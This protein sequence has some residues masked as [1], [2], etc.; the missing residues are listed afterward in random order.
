MSL[1]TLPY[2]A[3]DFPSDTLP[4]AHVTHQRPQRAHVHFSIY[5]FV[6]FFLLFRILRL[7][8]LLYI[9]FRV[10]LS[11]S[12]PCPR[13]CLLLYIFFSVLLPPL[14]SPSPPSPPPPLLILPRALGRKHKLWPTAGW[15]MTKCPI[16]FSL[17]M[18]LLLEVRL[19]EIVDSF[20]WLFW[21]YHLLKFLGFAV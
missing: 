5:S 1:D 21:A 20:L 6:S 4:P 12:P 9:F 16:F 13:V 8:F 3:P 18:A 11:P 10:P 17:R 14:Q 7:C 19:V 2:L 15:D